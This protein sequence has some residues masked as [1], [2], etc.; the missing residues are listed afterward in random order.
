MKGLCTLAALAVLAVIPP[1]SATSGAT[2]DNKS[3]ASFHRFTFAGLKTPE[4]PLAQF[5]GRAMLVVNTASR[6]GFTGQ[7]AGLQALHERYE[8][9]GL[10]VIG[11]PSN[12]FGN[13]EPGTAADIAGFCESVFGVTF[14]M[15]GKTVVRGAT[16]HP[17]YAAA[18]Q[19]LGE[20]Q[21][22]RWN[23]HKY[24]VARDGRLIAAFPSHVAPD[25]PRMIA[26]IERAL[27]V[28]PGT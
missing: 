1:A 6:C 12:D 26:A 18:A 27:S 5:A 3:V 16:R 28:P 11:V 20:A 15:A 13:Q 8:A 2:S 9:R 21:A 22:P 14:P 7:Y 17:F 25:D 10:T 24:V 23:F 19:A 4:L